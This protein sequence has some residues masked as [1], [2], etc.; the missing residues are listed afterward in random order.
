M[1]IRQINNKKY[2]NYSGKLVD[3]AGNKYYAETVPWK[4]I[5]SSNG[6]IEVPV[7][8]DSLK[9]ICLRVLGTDKASFGYVNIPK[10]AWHN[11]G[12]Y[13]VAVNCYNYLNGYVGYARFQVTKKEN[14][15]FTI[16]VIEGNYTNAWCYYK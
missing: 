3:K 2:M 9:E 1:E 4:A 7:K 14:N 5:E 11:D 16:S 13:P 15:S 12:T 6:T 10:E 8:W